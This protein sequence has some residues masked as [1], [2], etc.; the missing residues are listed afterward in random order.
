MPKYIVSWHTQVAPGATYYSGK[1]PIEA[2]DEETAIEA[3]Q[4]RV[5]YRGFQDWSQNHIVITS[6]ERVISHA[7]DD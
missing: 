2:E 6:I 3:A 4:W 1:E 7:H 5:W